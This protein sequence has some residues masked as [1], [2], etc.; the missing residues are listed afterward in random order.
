MRTVRMREPEPDHAQFG[1]LNAKCRDRICDA[2]LGKLA[3]DLGVTTTSLRRLGIGNN[4]SAWSFPMFDDQGRVRGIRL[5]ARDGSKYAVKGSREGLFLPSELEP[6]DRILVCE[7]PT[8]TAAMLDLGFEAIG[9][10]SCTGGADLVERFVRT[11]RVDDVAIIADEDEVG[12][13]GAYSLGARLRLI[14]S[15]VRVVTPGNEAGDARAWVNGG[16]RRRDVEVRIGESAPIQFSITT[17]RIGG[18]S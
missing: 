8:D 13:K 2:S 18:Q 16:A 6:V 1:I 11:I 12:R 15:V 14:C 9:R 5:R 3:D 10:P 7:G 4:G 17:N